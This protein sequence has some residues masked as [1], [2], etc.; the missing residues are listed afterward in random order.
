[1]KALREAREDS[2]IK[3]IVLRVNSPGGSAL[4]SEL[5]W[6]EVYL[7]SQTKP[8]IGSMGNLAASGGYYIM[9]PADTLICHPMTLTGSI[10][11][12]ATIPNVGK[13]MNDKLGL[14]FD[15]AKTNKYADFGSLYRPL[16]PAERSFFQA[17]IEKTY[18]T[19]ISHVSKGRGLPVTRVDEIGQGRVWSG[20]NAKEIGLIDEFGGL[21]KAIKI[22]ANKANLKNYRIVDYPKFEDPYQKLLKT[23]TG[24]M[25]ARRLKKEW[26]TLYNY[27][28][29]IRKMLD[30]KGIQMQLP[31]YIEIQ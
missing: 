13:L 20:I 26:G 27:F 3:A 31:F 15:V 14:T 17:G 9:A 18:G 29:T 12:F 1:M 5:I 11:V 21:T 19:F 16:R 28:I 30:N 8:V 24:D 4:A 7:A 2:T 10:G 22:A 25:Q 6:R 23:L